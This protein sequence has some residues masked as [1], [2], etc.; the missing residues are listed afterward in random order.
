MQFRKFAAAAGVIGGVAALAVGCSSSD[1]RSPFEEG[2][3]VT[4]TAALGALSGATCVLNRLPVEDLV[5]GTVT[6]DVDGIAS[7][8]LIG[9]NGPFLLT[10]SGGNYYD[11]ATATSMAFGGSIRSVVLPRQPFTPLNIGVTTAT[12]LVV[13]A[14]EGNPPGTINLGFVANA[15]L[16]VAR[17]LG[18]P[19]LNLLTPP[20]VVNQGNPLISGTDA[21]GLH[22]LILAGFSQLASE[23]DLTTAE[24]GALLADDV[25]AGQP[26]GTSLI[27]LGSPA[28]SSA[29]DFLVRFDAAVLAIIDIIVEPGI[30]DEIRANVIAQQAVA[31]SP[32]RGF[33]N[34]QNPEATPT[35]TPTPTITPTATPTVTPTATPT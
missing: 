32:G 24:L 12:E 27:G 23:L 13:A 3:T 5:L 10:C 25:A 4:A 21:R 18:L 19:N 31:Q 11:E 34:P 28:I 2:G 1:S 33:V 35:P 29:A 16:E 26:I 7:F 20:E 8:G 22:A 17:A 30:R 6:T 15:L 9:S 14:L